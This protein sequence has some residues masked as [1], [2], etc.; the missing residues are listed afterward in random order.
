MDHVDDLQRP[1][2]M[3]HGKSVKE[4]PALDDSEGVRCVDA[5]Q[6]AGDPHRDPANQPGEIHLSHG[7]HGGVPRDLRARGILF[8]FDHSFYQDRD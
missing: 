6:N 3:E 1:Q 7:G 8:Q 2:Q 4:I 5:Q